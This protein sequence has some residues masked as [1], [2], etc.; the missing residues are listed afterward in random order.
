MTLKIIST[1]NFVIKSSIYKFINIELANYPLSYPQY[2][3]K[4]M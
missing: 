2:V 1:E 3:E 4:I